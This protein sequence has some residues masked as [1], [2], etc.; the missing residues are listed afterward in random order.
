MTQARGTFTTEFARYEDVPD[1]IAKKVIEEA[2]NN[3]S[4]D[5]D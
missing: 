1:H 3:L 5:E 2:K 4:D